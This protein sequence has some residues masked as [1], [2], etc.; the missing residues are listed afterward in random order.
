MLIYVCIE[1]FNF[2]HR[3]ETKLN[4]NHIE[5]F[6]KYGI[7]NRDQ[8]LIDVITNWLII[9]VNNLPNFIFDSLKIRFFHKQFIY[10]KPLLGLIYGGKCSV[11]VTLKVKPLSS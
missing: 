1:L 7:N 4:E 3:L 8:F 11:Y 6:R 5:I 2:S 9:L 10:L